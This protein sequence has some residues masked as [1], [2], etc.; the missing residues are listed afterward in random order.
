M[1]AT[2]TTQQPSSCK[3]HVVPTTEKAQFLSK[4]A[5][6]ILK[7]ESD[8][9]KCLI[10]RF[11]SILTRMAHDQKKQH[12]QQHRSN[13]GSSRDRQEDLLA[14]GHCLRGLALLGKGKEA[15]SGFARVAIM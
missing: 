12:Q 7:L 9:T 1:T 4:L 8:T 13:G 5:P 10:S 14:I 11:S 15:E 2:R 6:R 3:T